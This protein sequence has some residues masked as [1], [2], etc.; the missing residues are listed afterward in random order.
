MSFLNRFF[1]KQQKEILEKQAEKN[2]PPP[3]GVTKGLRAD[4]KSA[5][6]VKT[7]KP[8]K[9][10]G[11][12]VKIG[13]KAAERKFSVEPHRLLIKP[14]ITEKISSMAADGKYAFEVAPSA[15]KISVKK[16]VGLLYGV[17]VKDVRVI[18]MKGKSVRYGRQFGKRRDW[19][20]AIVRLAPGEKIEIYEGV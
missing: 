20:K 11:K 10:S 14:L 19:K 2:L 16:A 8:P 4:K 12:G 1:K 13:V 15:D 18:N 5:K 7:K 3:R 17:D 6:I 9:N